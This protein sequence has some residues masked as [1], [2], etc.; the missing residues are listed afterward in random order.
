MVHLEEIQRIYKEKNGSINNVVFKS[1][2]NVLI[3]LF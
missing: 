2:G 1:L 3:L